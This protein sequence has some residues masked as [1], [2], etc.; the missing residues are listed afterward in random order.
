M[1]DEDTGSTGSGGLV[2]AHAL[3]AF[4]EQLHVVH[5][6]VDGAAVSEEQRRRWQVRLAAISEGATVDLLRAHAQLRRLD[7]D[8]DRHA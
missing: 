8:L 2:D 4:T 3:L 5:G 6:R 1:R 7:A